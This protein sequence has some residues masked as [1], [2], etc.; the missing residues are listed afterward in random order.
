MR[1]LRELIQRFAG[2]FFRRRKD[3][4]LE[5]EIESHLQLHIDD[6]L[7]AGMTLEEARREAIVKFGGIEAVKEAFRDQRGFP[8]LET[9]W[10]DIRYGARMLR[11]NPGFTAVAVLTL[12]LGIGATTALFTVAYGVLLKPLPLPQSE[13]LVN[14]FE[15]G[16]GSKISKTPVSAQNYLDWKARCK[17]FTALTC[18][19]YSPVNIGADGGMPERWNAARVH[20]D[21]FKVTGVNPSLGIPFAP[22]HFAE[23]A[24]GVVILSHGVWRERFG[25]NSNVLG[26]TIPLNGRVRT[27]IGIMPPGFQTPGQS[28]VWLPKVFANQELEDRGSKAFVVLGRLRGDVTAAQA[29]SDVARV[30]ANLAHDFP[31]MLKGWSAF[32]VPVLQGFA[33]PMRLPLLVLSAAVSVV[34]LMACVNVANLLLARGATRVGEMATRSALG[35]ARGRLVRQLGIE[36]LILAL[37]GGIAGSLFAAILLKLVIG[38]APA[39][40][41]RVNQVTLDLWTLG[42]ALGATAVTSLIFG[43]AP[44]WQLARVQPMWAMRDS[45]PNTTSRT[46]RISKSLV[47]FQIAAS[48]VV[49]VAAGLLLRSFDRLMRT[50][51]GFRPDELLTVR[52]ELPAGKYNVE[53]KR[54]Q[55]ARSLVEKLSTLPGVES[56]TTATQ[57]PLQGWGQVITRIEGRP[58]PPP[59]QAPATGFAAVTPDYFRT[60]NIP[61]LRGRGFAP[62]DDANAVKV[63]VINQAFARR[64]FPDEEP[65]GRRV[66]LGFAEPPQ[67]I[68]IVGIAADTRNESIENQPQD[69]VFT[70]LDQAP[71]F[72]GAPISVAIRSRAGATDLVPGLREAVWSLDKDQPLHNLKPMKQVLFEAT[73]QRRFTLI[74]L[75]VFAG[76]ALLLAIIGLYGVLAYGVSKRKRE[77]GIRM[78]L[79]A[80]RGDVLRLILREGVLLVMVGVASGLIGAVAAIRLMRNLLYETAPTDPTTFAAI[81]VLLSVVTLLACLLPALRAAK[82]DPMMA[83]RCE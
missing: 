67:W 63:G 58:S 65:I 71:W 55:F 69:Q 8:P 56:A 22:E 40:L 64:F 49:L 9:L 2:V 23:G 36:S 54:S 13:R 80:R 59:S 83:L 48:M 26:K 78:A 7:R 1:K 60:L 15:K 50:D 34:L 39:G 30:A 66:E 28:R 46:G 42:F 20:D 62:S 16:P 27:V 76:L 11:K 17:S 68:E 6:N 82:V 57:L 31:E 74:V 47:V 73:A 79:G 45:A 43:F 53:G 52:L 24:D 41:P 75:G 70:P 21:F 25:G 33:Q 19:E 10:Q 32:V 14:V 44:A 5:D 37:L 3:H 35:A 61:I 81:T 77:I 72:V 29:T 51:Y 38:A 12:A 18:F 4:E